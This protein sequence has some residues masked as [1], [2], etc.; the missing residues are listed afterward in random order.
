MAVGCK[1]ADQKVYSVKVGDVIELDYTYPVVPNAMPKKVSIKQ[2]FG[3][4]IDLSPIGVRMVVAPRLVGA[5]TIGFFLDAKETGK[6]TV[7][8]VI[9]ANEYEYTFAVK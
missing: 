9:D 4:A 7:T 3:G 5:S 2:T 1:I 8:L 6:E